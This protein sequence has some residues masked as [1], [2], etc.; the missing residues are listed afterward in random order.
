ADL[1]RR[2]L[3]MRQLAPRFSVRLHQATGGNPFFLLQ[4]LRSLQEQGLLTRDA[5]GI[6]HT[7]WDAPGADYHELPLPAGLR[8][9]IDARL[10]GLGAQE[11]EALAA[12]AVLGQHF[13]PATWAGMAD[14]RR[15]TTGESDPSSVVGDQWSVVVGQ[16]LKRQFLVEEGAGYRFGHETLRE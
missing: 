14:D 15:P 4:A 1:I 8:D 6:W 10:R 16:L 11:R 7:E 2:L 5:Q 12:A 9:A 13:T 3:R